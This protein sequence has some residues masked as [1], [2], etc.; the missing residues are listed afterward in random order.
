MRIGLG[1]GVTRAR[2]SAAMTEPSSGRIR[3]TVSLT[4]AGTDRELIRR[5]LGALRE[6]PD[7]A[8][9][10]PRGADSVTIA[11][12]W[13]S[14][15]LRE[16][17]GLAPAAA[18]RL[19]QPG[20]T[21]LP[22]LHGWPDHLRAAV[23]PRWTVLPG[24]HDPLGRPLT[25]PDIPAVVEF[26]RRSVDAGASGIAVTAA[27]S[28]AV[29]DHEVA[30]AEAIK[31]ALP[32]L[33]VVLAHELGALGL[34]GRENT[35]TLNAALGPL[36]ETVID[37]CRAEVARFH[38][39]AS[40][41]FVRYDGA[42]VNSES[43][44]RVPVTTADAHLAAELRG[45]STLAGVENALVLAFSAH[46]TELGL[47]D[48]GSPQHAPQ[49]TATIRP[50][51]PLSLPLPTHETLP[52]GAAELAGPDGPDVAARLLRTVTRLQETAVPRPVLAAGDPRAAGH[53]PPGLEAQVSE[54]GAAAAAVGAS[55]AHPVAEVS[56]VVLTERGDLPTQQ[57]QARVEALAAVTR[58]G[59]DPASAQIVAERVA[60][61][62][63]LPSNVHRLWV[64]A[65]GDI[66]GEQ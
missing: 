65:A 64:R 28:P 40:L 16:G 23:G 52:E 49:G 58:A 31:R 66:G 37:T 51:M 47:I 15:V 32:D 45:A 38:P 42:V 22:P 54:H 48:A 4:T 17:H 59:A 36:A 14:R 21:V 30:A 34:R 25:E 11:G 7:A 10:A 12:D 5:C 1:V 27:G 46:Q 24:G 53:L 29:P 9:L 2:A 60:P 20:G 56:R 50:G 26:A 55:R 41:W 39:R 43:F 57:D 8:A 19:A 18:V 3:S 61:V 13:V 6:Q 33:R 44:R 63:Y 62:G 35:A